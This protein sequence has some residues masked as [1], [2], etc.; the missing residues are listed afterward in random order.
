MD[1]GM[2][3]GWKLV[4]TA[5]LFLAGYLSGAGKE[6]SGLESEWASAGRSAARG[7]GRGLRLALAVCPPLRAGRRHCG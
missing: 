3:G 2:L 1:T 7:L 5:L 4:A 6:R